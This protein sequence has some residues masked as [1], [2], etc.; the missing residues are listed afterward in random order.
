MHVLGGGEHV[1]T[2]PS[3][4]GDEVDLVGVV[5]NLLEVVGDFLLDFSVSGL[6]VLDGLVVHLVGADNHLLDS[7]GEGEESVLSGLSLLGD[8]RLELSL[9]GGDDEDGNISLG[10]SGDHVLD[11]ISVSGGIDDGEHGL[12]GLEL[13]EGDIN[14]DTSLSLGLE[15]VEDPSVL[16]RSLTHLFGFLLELLDDSLVDTT[17]LVDEMAGGGGLS[18]VHMTDD[19]ERN[20]ILFF[21]H[22]LVV[23]FV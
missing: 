8:T 12:G 2:V 18:G 17:A 19:D 11:E 1:I 6:G 9:S 20:M 16:E 23:C 7:H 3:G 21:S 10:G 14:G 5:T 4:D 13:P 15:L 22:L